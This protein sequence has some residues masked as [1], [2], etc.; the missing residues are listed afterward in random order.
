[1]Q[2]IRT[3]FYTDTLLMIIVM[4][5]DIKIMFSRKWKDPLKSS[6][7]NYVGP[8]IKMHQK[9]ECRGGKQNQNKGIKMENK[10]ELNF[11]IQWTS[12]HN[13][14]AIK[15]LCPCPLN[16]PYLHSGKP[17]M[18][19]PYWNTSLRAADSLYHTCK[20]KT[21]SEGRDYTEK[22]LFFSWSI[23]PHLMLKVNFSI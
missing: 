9:N 4:Q 2:W 14:G 21:L 17:Q 5:W 8:S 15:K 20:C 23:K 18:G 1:M 19:D 22:K 10:F 11:I 3:K 16:T 6:A 12:K 7:C 13:L